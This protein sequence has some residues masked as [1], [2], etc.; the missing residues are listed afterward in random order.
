[1][2]QVYRRSIPTREGNTAR[3][4][5]QPFSEASDCAGKKGKAQHG[6]GHKLGPEDIQ[7]NTFEENSPDNDQ[8]V[9]QG[10]QI[11]QPLH[12]NGHVGDGKDETAEHEEG[13]DEKECRHHGLLLR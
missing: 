3:F 4:L 12:D 9:P 11:G 5:I 6:E 10:V 8:E 7:P 2:A 13:Q 1:M